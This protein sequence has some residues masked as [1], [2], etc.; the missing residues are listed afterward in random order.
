MKDQKDKQCRYI[1][2][3]IVD[4]IYHGCQ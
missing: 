2:T 3:A 4:H 1:F